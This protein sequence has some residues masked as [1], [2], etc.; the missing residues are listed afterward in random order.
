MSVNIQRQIVLGFALITTLGSLGRLPKTIGNPEGGEKE[1]QQETASVKSDERSDAT[2]SRLHHSSLFGTA[3]LLTNAGQLDSAIGQLSSHP[4]DKD[5]DDQKLLEGLR[6]NDLGTLYLI[7]SNCELKEV[8][9]QAI[10]HRCKD[11]FGEA[12]KLL[13]KSD[14]DLAVCLENQSLLAQKMGLNQ[15]ALDLKNSA[16]LLF[17]KCSN[18]RHP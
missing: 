14:Y 15:K 16:S 8:A 12:Q 10:L 1:R 17:E 13:E 3:L 6:L 18:T 5:K 4:F 2:P 9:K 7:E 11:L